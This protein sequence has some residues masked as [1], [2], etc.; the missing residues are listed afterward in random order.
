MSIDDV[1]L[2]R[3]FDLD[4]MA[5]L[6]ERFAQFGRDDNGG[7]TRLSFSDEDR[8]A[9]DAFIRLLKTEFNLKIRTDPLGNIFARREGRH[10]QWPVIMTGSHLDS[11][12]NGGKYDGPAGVF[13]SLEAFRALDQLGIETQHPFELCVLSSEEPNTFGISTFG[14]RGMVGTLKKTEVESLRD[15]NGDALSGALANIGGNLDQMGRAVRGKDEIRYFV[16]LHI[17]QLPHLERENKQI[18][19]VE[20]ITGIYRE[21]VTVSGVASHCG[22]TPMSDRKDALCAASEIVLGLEQAAREEDGNAVGT[23]G[24]INVSPNSINITPGQ[25]LLDLEI[26]SFFPERITRVVDK[27]ANRIDLVGKRRQVRIDRRVTYDSKPIHFSPV[28]VQAIA[29]AARQL[30]L[31]AYNEVSMAGHDAAHINGIC[32]AGMIFIPCRNGLS[33]CPEEFTDTQNIIKGAQCLLKTLLLLD[34]K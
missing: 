26:R 29:E 7:V 18:G 13:S 32:Q 21:A 4:R 25:V 10:P 5:A 24:H 11:V 9:R 19:I 2:K 1:D 15:D 3:C 22:T 16:E 34:L 20:G 33:H 28:V 14:S 8:Q 31:K 30:D 23:I 17:E 6:I 27:V 12:R